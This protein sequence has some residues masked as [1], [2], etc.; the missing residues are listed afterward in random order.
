MAARQWLV[1]Q[2]TWATVQEQVLEFCDTIEIPLLGVVAAGEPYQAFAIEE[3]LSV[4]TTL[5]GGKQ[6]FALH[7]RGN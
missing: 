4:P 7:V 6:V 1:E 2:T 3:V 5:W